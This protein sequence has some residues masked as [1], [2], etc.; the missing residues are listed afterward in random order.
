MPSRLVFA[1]DSFKGT[2]S[3]R[4]AEELLEEA[5][6]A[7]F[8]DVSC[9]SLPMA[10]GGE[11]TVEAVVAATG[12]RIVDVP[13]SD[14]LGRPLTSTYALLPDGRALIETAAASGL[15]LLSPAERDPLRTSTFGTG[16]LISH[17]LDHGT[18]DI[19]VALGGSATNDGGMGLLRA[20]GARFLDA[21][22]HE[23]VGTGAD[24][25]RVA[26]VDLSELDRRL[27]GVSFHVMC[28]VDSPLLGPQGASRLFGP[29]KGASAAD[30]R[31]LE[32][33]MASY[34]RLLSEACGRP[35]VDGP[36]LGAAGG[37]CAALQL[38]LGAD[39]SSGVDRV[40]DLVGF[41][42]ALAG[43]DLCITGEG[44]ADA[45]T[46]R[47]KVMCGVARRCRAAGVGCVAIVGGMDPDAVGLLD[48]GIDALIPTVI[49]ATELDDALGRAEEN[50]R[51]AAHR[52]FTLLSLG[53]GLRGDYR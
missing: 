48:C 33:G 30:V 35:Y 40:L 7:H 5:A 8:H 50:F 28:D 3:S 18:C 16:Q 14:P 10:D 36:G 34:A 24:L 29:Q 53:M 26:S 43:A 47:G 39:A 1:C 46:A 4:H 49:D 2:L 31:M 22:G 41:D 17:A 19:T 23:L 51:L 21:L 11:G 15:T 37:V 45:Q 38:A 6:R 12:G 42:D 13:S 27:E 44:H 20:L 32:T 9:V 25:V 52:V